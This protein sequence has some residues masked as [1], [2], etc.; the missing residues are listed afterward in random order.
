[1][2]DPFVLASKSSEIAE[3]GLDIDWIY[4]ILWLVI[5]YIFRKRIV[6]Y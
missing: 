4:N 5:F 2:Y 1:M 6:E 3:F